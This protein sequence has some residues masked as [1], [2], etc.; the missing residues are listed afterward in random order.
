[1]SKGLASG[2]PWSGLFRSSEVKAR[3]VCGQSLSFVFPFLSLSI[4]RRSWKRHLT[5][6]F[7][8]TRL[9]AAGFLVCLV[10]I[11]HLPFAHAL[12]KVKLTGESEEPGGRAASVPAPLGAMASTGEE[13]TGDTVEASSSEFCEKAPGGRKAPCEAHSHK[14]AFEIALRVRPSIAPF[15]EL[16]VSFSSKALSSSAL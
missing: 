5:T 14:D 15:S 10:L 6:H 7:P 2:L 16:A 13:E 1:M 4:L 11:P 3:P 8:K 9:A 12:V